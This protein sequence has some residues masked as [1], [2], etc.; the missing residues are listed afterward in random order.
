[1]F[2]CQIM[3]IIAVPRATKNGTNIAKKSP[4]LL[5]RKILQNMF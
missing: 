3:I 2:F 1:M 5:T 4:F